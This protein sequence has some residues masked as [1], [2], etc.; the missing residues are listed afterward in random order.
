MGQVSEG[1]IILLHFYTAPEEQ[2]MQH[3]I[4]QPLKR[5]PKRLNNEL[6]QLAETSYHNSS[7]RLTI[8]HR[9]ELPQLILTTYG[10]S[11]TALFQHSITTSISTTIQAT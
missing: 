9:S 6:P 1:K 3:I 5:Q 11:L 2:L 8:T 10:N 4:H 7:Q